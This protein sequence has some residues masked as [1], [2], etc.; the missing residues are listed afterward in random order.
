MIKGRG[1]RLE[2]EL[3]GEIETDMC[4]LARRE[5]SK[6]AR[7]HQVIEFKDLREEHA[8]WIPCNPR[9]IAPRLNSFTSGHIV[10]G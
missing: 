10:R 9:A 3:W 2:P 8:K 4:R 7:Q 6:I 1:S 5:L